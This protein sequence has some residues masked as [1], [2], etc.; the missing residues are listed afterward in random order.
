MTPACS[1]CSTGGCCRPCCCCCYTR[2]SLRVTS[3]GHSLLQENQI[4]V[5]ALLCPGAPE[6]QLQEP[7]KVC[8]R[9]KG[10]KGPRCSVGRGF[11]RCPALSGCSGCSWLARLMEQPLPPAPASLQWTSF[12]EPSPGV[13]LTEA[14]S[15]GGH[16]AP[17]QL[18][19]LSVHPLTLLWGGGV[20]LRLEAG[21]QGPGSE[22]WTQ[23]PARN[24]QQVTLGQ[25][26]FSLHLSLA[27]V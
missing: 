15:F 25:L 9:N 4:P 10:N 14:G 12:L 22:T 23:T 26:P 20:A 5:G 2:G 11:V 8:G 21:A 7:G 24:K 3:L 18:C 1:S 6:A 13:S 17:F 27:S 16:Q 19:S